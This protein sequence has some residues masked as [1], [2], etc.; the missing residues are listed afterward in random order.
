MRGQILVVARKQVDAFST[1]IRDKDGKVGRVDLPANGA[2]TA[3][4]A[5]LAITHRDPVVAGQRAHP[6]R[7]AVEKRLATAA[8]KAG[9]QPADATETFAEAAAGKHRFK[10]HASVDL[11]KRNV[12]QVRIAREPDS[13]SAADPSGAA[14]PGKEVA[15]VVKR[16]GVDELAE[17][18]VDQG[19]VRLAQQV[20]DVLGRAQ[21][22]PVE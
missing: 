22:D 4:G 7:S 21:H 6:P 2:A 11:L 5:P 10:K 8:G 9:D 3:F 19:D 20:M 12:D 13:I 1:A 14:E 15:E 18:L 16:L 17:R